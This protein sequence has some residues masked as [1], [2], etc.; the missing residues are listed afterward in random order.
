MKEFLPK[1][2]KAKRLPCPFPF[3]PLNCFLFP[4]Q[5]SRSN[6]VQAGPRRVT[7]LLSPS[8]S[9]MSL[10]FLHAYIWKLHF[11]FCEPWSEM[12]GDQRLKVQVGRRRREPAPKGG[13]PGVT[14]DA[15]HMPLPAVSSLVR[16]QPRSTKAICKGEPGAKSEYLV[17]IGLKRRHS[18][19]KYL[20]IIIILSITR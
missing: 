11:L 15:P 16:M 17:L 9:L 20:M 10:R 12:R 3:F 4:K 2:E 8:S 1:T 5:L 18:Q 14:Q 7:R 13:P 6:W 19:G